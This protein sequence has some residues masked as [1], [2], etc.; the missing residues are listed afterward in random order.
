MRPKYDIQ[1]VVLMRTSSGEAST[2]LHLLT[3]EFGLVRARAQGLRKSGAKLACATQTLSQC[4]AMLVRGKETWQLRGAT[5]VRN[6]FR[7]L[8]DDARERA[9]RVAQLILRLVRGEMRDTIVYELF[10]AY[11]DA[12][13]T[14]PSTKADAIECM[15]ALTLLRALGLDAGV[16]PGGEYLYN[17]ET[18]D[19]VTKNRRQYILR[20][21][22]GISASGL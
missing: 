18:L 4:E 6:R 21:N 16:M 8:S 1:A 12:L 22:Q 7:E 3:S 10:V 15:G 5:L 19:E 11:L 9:G 14:F 17:N 2:V 20:I 13:S